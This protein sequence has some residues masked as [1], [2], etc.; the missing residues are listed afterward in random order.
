MNQLNQS[1]SRANHR[2]WILFLLIVLLLNTYGMNTPAQE[3]PQN[4]EISQ[5]IQQLK[6]PNPQ[7]RGNAAEAL[8][9]LGDVSAVPALLEALKDEDSSVRASAAW[10]LSIL[11]DESAVPE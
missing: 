9:N 4:E 10:A 2:L 1:L 6:D 7:V 3:P 11:E 8:G 5:L